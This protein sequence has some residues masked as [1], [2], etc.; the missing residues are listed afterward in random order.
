MT[1]LSPSLEA[2]RTDRT[3]GLGCH[4]RQ[5]HCLSWLLI[6]VILQFWY[7]CNVARATT[8]QG[9]EKIVA[10]VPHDFPPTYFCNAVT[11]KPA[12][13]AI[14]VM[15]EVARRA[16][17]EVE[18]IFG[19]PWD[20]ILDM[21][22]S[23]YVDVV[24]N[25]TMEESRKK[26]F[27]FTKP[28]E[29]LPISYIVRKDQE[30]TFPSPGMTVGVI[31][32]SVAH[33]YLA[34]REDI[35]IV[36][37]TE[38]Q[39]LL[40]DLLSGQ[41]DM[42]LTAV[43][44]LMKLAIDAGLDERIEVVH[45]PVVE[46]IRAMA[47]RQGDVEL[48]QRLDAVIVDF[49]KSDSYREIYQ[50]W[51]G[52]PEPFWTP[53]KMFT[54]LAVV[55]TIVV[56]LMTLLRFRATARLNQEL[57]NA[58][59]LAERER[60]KANSILESVN[61]GISIQ[62]R[63]LRVL[64]QNPRH[65]EI[66]GAHSGE[67]C[68]RAYQDRESA[69]E[70][71]PVMETFRTGEPICTTI[72]ITKATGTSHLEIHTSPIRNERGEITAVI[73]SVRDVTAR[74]AVEEQCHKDLVFIETLMQNSPMAIRVY[75]AETGA[76]MMVNQAAA[77]MAG[78]SIAQMQQQNFRTLASWQTAGIIATAEEVITDG[79]SRMVEAELSTSFNKQISVACFFS[80]FLV[81]D[82][83]YLLVMGRDVTEE[84]KLE[85]EKKQME[86][87]LLHV[88]KLESLGVLAGGIAHDFNN[89][90]TAIV[91]NADL[92]VLRLEPASPVLGN[93]RRIQASA[94]RATDLAKQMLAYSGKGKF[95]VEPIDLNRLVEEMV[96]MLEV[97][98]SKKAMLR[99]DLAESLP[100][101]NADA[102]QIRQITMNL[103]INASEAIGDKSGV[104]AITTGYIDCDHDYL[105]DA[106]VCDN[107]AGG[108]YVYLE[109]A[110][111]G[112]GMDKETASRIF[113]PFFTTKFTGRGLGMAAVQGIVRGHKGA[114]KVDSE[115]GKGSSFKVLL[116]AGMKPAEMAGTEEQTEAW[117]GSGTILLVDDEE[118]IRGLG[119][120]MLQILG[121]E[122]FTA[123]DGREAVEIFRTRNDI[124]TI[125]LDLTMP[126]L[127]GEQ[128]FRELRSLDPDVRVI[129]SSGYSEYEV[130]QKFAG[131]GLS[132]FLHKPFT[133][134]GL[135]QVLK[136]VHLRDHEPRKGDR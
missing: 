111:T 40:F 125:I 3:T 102:T 60:V 63:S 106:S 2:G 56:I 84:K 110:D 129:I 91:G 118:S 99:L 44:N 97:S 12:G 41:V 54:F 132:G 114:I 11:G 47:L 9:A 13:F 55:V 6:L 53:T 68:Y 122:V 48:R 86:K 100:S 20:E 95:V 104:I 90:L 45:P 133:M 30:I 28:I 64:Y 59:E 61:D 72:S 119:R 70:T 15:N 120:E 105:K 1:N 126:H 96:H 67:F 117:R 52:K 35:T 34:P 128:A 50:R 116:P 135:C 121:L 71:C 73:E 14:D 123:G 130:S 134:D 75:D 127:D 29:T 16:G 21:L 18:Y 69:C 66:A 80:R 103:V 25:L 7:P 46:G 65:I 115:P 22:E 88:Q 83:P 92:A 131:E 57:R 37:R 36:I 124:K 24:P 74:R 76:C 77:D 79:R 85:D 32:G 136:T 8:A 5:L 107:I 82:K 27:A 31:K 89:I 93:L 98:I 23:G 108:P 33:S 10:A 19:E 17:F 62:D 87:Q 112:C 101:V 113:D 81:N 109:V 26:R 94:V 78:G 58:Y 49:V 43:P 51:W 4:R 39:H 42:I 38:L